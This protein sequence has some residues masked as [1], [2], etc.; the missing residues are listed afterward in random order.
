MGEETRLMRMVRVAKEDTGLHPSKRWPL[1]AIGV[2]GF[3]VLLWAD[4]VHP[5][6]HPSEGAGWSWIRTSVWGI[7]CGLFVFPDLVTSTLAGLAA[8]RSGKNE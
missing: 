4:I 7:I 3:A 2:I 5:T 6:L 8:I 1:Q